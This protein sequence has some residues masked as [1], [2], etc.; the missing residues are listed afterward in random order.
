[1]SDDRSTGDRSI[2][3]RAMYDEWQDRER[4][5]QLLDETEY[6]TELGMELAED[7]QRVVAGE[8]SEAEFEERYH[9]A[10][11]EEFGQDDRELSIPDEFEDD[12]G[13]F[14]ET[15]Q[16]LADGEDVDRREVMKAGGVAAMALS[17]SLGG[18]KLG[19]P[20]ESAAQAG[21]GEGEEDTQYGM[22]INLNNCDGCLACMVACKQENNTSRGSNWMYV[23]AFEDEGQDDESFLVRPCQHC[24]EAACEKV[25]PVGARHTRE[26]DGIV[27]TD[28]E[29]CIGCRYCQVACPYGVNYFQWGE[30]DTPDSELDA[31]HVYDERDRRVDSRPVKGTMGKCTFCPTRQDGQQGED[32]VGTTACED[33]CAMDAIHFGDMNDPESAP[34]QHLEEYRNDQSNDR[35]DWE[36]RKEHTVSTFR[37]LEDKGTDPNVVYVGNEPG[38][39]AHQVE[40]PVTYE[41]VG[42]VD[43]RK[44]EVLDKGK[45]ANDGGGETA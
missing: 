18:A 31:E 30:P 2:D 45:A 12:D 19:S 20:D 28:Y 5:E 42:L 15:V 4:M 9:D 21:G 17:G 44:E 14:R 38:E 23:M 36:N 16:R 35:E 7:A 39:H 10:V 11:V 32:K 8:L 41:D 3:D 13:G 34:N 1:V 22:V 43:N 26:D 6:D 25:C 33:A 29:I 40:G 24:D 37:L 27:L